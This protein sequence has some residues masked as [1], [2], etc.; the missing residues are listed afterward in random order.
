MYIASWIDERQR[1]GK[2]GLRV[3][4][5]YDVNVILVGL[6]VLAVHGLYG[7]FM[8]AGWSLFFRHVLHVLGD[9]GT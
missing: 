6:E 7:L 2:D 3:V 1:L 8:V 5:F 4:R 9:R